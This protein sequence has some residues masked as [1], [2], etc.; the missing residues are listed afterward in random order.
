MS[1]TDRRMS[2]NKGYTPEGFAEKVFHVHVHARGDN[3]E[4]YFRDY[5]LE[6]PDTAHQYEALKLSLL[7]AYRYN[8]DG[9]TAA[10]AKFVAHV[11]GLAKCRQKKKE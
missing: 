9:Y 2:F 7:P 11:T 6:N 5:L 10:K 4:L 8:R 3:V 1:M